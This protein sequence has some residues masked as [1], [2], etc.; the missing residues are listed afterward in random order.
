MFWIIGL[1]FGSTAAF[2]IRAVR[3]K[4][5]D[6]G[7][8]AGILAILLLFIIGTLTV[9]GLGVFTHVFY[10][11]G[12]EMRTWFWSDIFAAWSIAVILI[13]IGIFRKNSR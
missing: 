4:N 13:V 5:I 9:L 6:L 1:L 8:D 11:S 2:R 3:H 10:T 7:S 12:G